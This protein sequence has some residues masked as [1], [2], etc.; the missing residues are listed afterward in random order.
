LIVYIFSPHSLYLLCIS[1]R[2]IEAG[3]KNIFFFLQTTGSTTTTTMSKNSQGQALDET[4]IASEGLVSNPLDYASTSS[5]NT[6][7]DKTNKLSHMPQQ[8]GDNTTIPNETSPIPLDDDD[9]LDSSSDGTHPSHSSAS[10]QQLSPHQSPSVHTDHIDDTQ[11]RKRRQLS[12]QHTNNNNDQ[13]SDPTWCDDYGDH[14]TNLEHD[15]VSSISLQLSGDDEECAS[16]DMSNAD[17]VE[18]ITPE[19]LHSGTSNT[20]VVVHDDSANTDQEV[21]P[22][23][24]HSTNQNV[25][26]MPQNEQSLC[27]F[28]HTITEYSQKR[29]SGCKKA[30]YSD[31]TVDER[32]NKWRLIV[33]VNGNGRAS[34]HHLSL[35]LQVRSFDCFE[36]IRLAR[37]VPGIIEK[38]FLRH[39]DFSP[40]FVLS[41]FFAVP[42]IYLS[43]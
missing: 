37:S 18:P 38:S 25:A 29:D 1:S 2:R 36:T 43:K 22:S 28:S 11:T 33:Y 8:S 7:E 39:F 9:P 4:S 6:I 26:W 10:Q 35:F 12:L 17:H 24:H 15:R 16:T 19:K 34:N 27:E 13:S 23:H 32:G 30:E 31:V 42:T 14:V 3:I 5:D 20:H 41:L 21:P 40:L